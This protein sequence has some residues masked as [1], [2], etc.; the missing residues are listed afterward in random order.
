MARMEPQ[1]AFSMLLEAT[2]SP[3]WI[4]RSNAADALGEIEMDHRQ[5]AEALDVL[6]GLLEDKYP[7]VPGCCSTVYSNRGRR[8]RQ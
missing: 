6:R 5:R 2:K 4:I 7:L 3:D 1:R 8:R